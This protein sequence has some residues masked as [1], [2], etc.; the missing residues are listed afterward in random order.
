MI[1]RCHGPCVAPSAWRHARGLLSEQLPHLKM[2]S[3]H[4]LPWVHLVSASIF[5]L[6]VHSSHRY[7]AHP[8]LHTNMFDCAD[9]STSNKSE[10]IYAWINRV[11]AFPSEAPAS[12]PFESGVCQKKRRNP[13]K[14]AH[15]QRRRS[16]EV[17][18]VTPP[19]S[20][21]DQRCLLRI[22]PSRSTYAQHLGDA[23]PEATP[24]PPKRSRGLRP[25]G[26]V[27][28]H[29]KS[30][31]LTSSPS[32][33]MQSSSIHPQSSA[34]E[35]SSSAMSHVRSRGQSRSPVKKHQLRWLSDKAVIYRSYV[36]ARSLPQLREGSELAVL[37][38]E[39]AHI[40]AR[41]NA[42]LPR[43]LQ[44]RNT[45]LLVAGCQRVHCTDPLCSI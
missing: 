37:N 33:R 17:K 40:H 16:L 4:R 35:T 29:T 3:R 2:T 32:Y 42:F 21:D 9:S 8:T 45:I 25:A 30:P 28:I 31:P 27:Q 43:Q 7:V 20:A 34:S 15:W 10:F 39:L 5:F 1:P 23:E 19:S 44:V 13:R 18:M 26:D 6:C 41:S 12:I 22:Q 36:E 24:R 38:A 11:A 14:R